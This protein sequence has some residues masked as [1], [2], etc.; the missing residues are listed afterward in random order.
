MSEMIPHPISDVADW[1]SKPTGPSK[2]LLPSEI[3]DPVE[4]AALEA[5]MAADAERRSIFPRGD[6]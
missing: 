3:K 2:I 6:D 5:A 1:G 4:R